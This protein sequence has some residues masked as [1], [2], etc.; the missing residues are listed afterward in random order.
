M[1]PARIRN[2]GNEGTRAPKSSYMLSNLKN[3]EHEAADVRL[4]IA[5][6]R[7]PLDVGVFATRGAALR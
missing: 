3:R 6:L 7:F 2:P 4:F 1:R 5:N